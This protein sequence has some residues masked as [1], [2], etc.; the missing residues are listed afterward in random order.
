M[1]V[2]YRSLQQ[3]RQEEME[4]V[5]RPTPQAVAP[6]MSKLVLRA[7]LYVGVFVLLVAVG[8]FLVNREVAQIPVPP[9][10]ETFQEGQAVEQQASAEPVESI[11]EDEAEEQAQP[12]SLVQEERSMAPEAPLVRQR[13]R[14]AEPD[15]EPV[16]LTKPSM[17]LERHFAE[18]ARQNE[19]LLSLERKM[20]QSLEAGRMQ[21]SKELLGSME[22]KLQ[23]PRSATKF[24]WEGYMAL[25]QK[26][27]ARA[28]ELYRKALSI[29]PSD[30]V[31]R[32]NLVYALSGQGKYDE[33][34]KIY[35]SL[36]DDYPMDDR[37]L[38]L[39]DVLAV[40]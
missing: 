40:R 16:D 38:A 35:R 31:S 1:S 21:Q 3:L 22:Q 27:F 10:E 12:R 4:R 26:D 17:T 15:S 2:I 18:R 14:R 36:A 9:P 39:G 11:L 33:A 19:A 20:V 34:R 23:A 13:M 30:F 6:R 24:K 5:Q 8:L 37:V 7:L 29:K 32:I 28:E 25:K